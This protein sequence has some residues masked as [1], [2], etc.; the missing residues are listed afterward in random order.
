[1]PAT[2]KAF[3]VMKTFLIILFM[4]SSVIA[5]AQTPLAAA[6]QALKMSGDINAIAIWPIE[7]KSGVLGE[8]LLDAASDEVEQVFARKAQEKKIKVVT[9]RQLGNL[10]SE[11]KLTSSDRSSFD[12]LAK[13]AGVDAVIL[14]S[15]TLSKS[16]CLIVA[17]NV[18][19]TSRENKGEVISS[20]KPFKFG[21]RSGDLD[22][23]GCD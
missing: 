22:V 1:M 21:T 2:I 3:S 5:E 18:V 9:R 13:S 16:G 7:L 4:L 20:A 8:D 11:I 17:I 19:G 14:P 10:L 23:T 6:S 12:K 15:A